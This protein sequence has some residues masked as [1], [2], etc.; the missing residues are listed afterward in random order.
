MVES[1][2]HLRGKL[3]LEIANRKVAALEAEIEEL[4]A[5]L[6]QPPDQRVEQLRAELTVLQEN[7]AEA[8]KAMAGQEFREKAAALQRV[9]ATITCTFRHEPYGKD[10]TSNI[11]V[12]VVI[13]PLLG[14][15]KAYGPPFPTV[16]A[17]WRI[18]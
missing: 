2:T 17:P 1:F 15:A 5:Q 13:E 3:A 7:A 14:E 16:D 6:Q 9:I 11:L 4:S 8:Q 18:R 12:E 10:R